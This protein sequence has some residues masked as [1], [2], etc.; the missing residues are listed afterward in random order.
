MAFG[1]I[2]EYSPLKSQ[3]IVTKPPLSDK[4]AHLE[5]VAREFDAFFLG[6]L[7]E[8]MR[9]PMFGGNGR[10][11]GGRGEEVFGQLWTTEVSKGA[12]KNTKDGIFGMKKLIMERYAKYVQAEENLK[13]FSTIEVVA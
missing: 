10:F 3:A 8:N 1:S 12:S 9:K 4:M 11:D 5:K 6:K 13:Q 2:A 7:M